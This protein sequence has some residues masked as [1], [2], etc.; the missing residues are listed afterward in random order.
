MHALDAL[1]MASLVLMSLDDV[2]VV[3]VVK[4][5]W[6]KELV[7]NACVV[8]ATAAMRHAIIESL[9]IMMGKYQLNE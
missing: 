7:L 1:L 5:G 4:A 6:R 8:C 9:Y 2:V 3:A